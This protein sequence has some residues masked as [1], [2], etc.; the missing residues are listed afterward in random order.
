MSRIIGTY[1]PKGGCFLSCTYSICANS[2]FTS[3]ETALAYY[4][5][6]ALGHQQN[7][8]IWKSHYFISFGLGDSPPKPPPP[9]IK[10]K[11]LKINDLATWSVFCDICVHPGRHTAICINAVCLPHSTFHFPAVIVTYLCCCVL[12]GQI[13]NWFPPHKLHA[14]GTWSRKGLTPATS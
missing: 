4:R 12:I 5:C 1:L 14:S 11:K 3:A 9:W 10:N 8:F 6:H 13:C 7:G 2:S